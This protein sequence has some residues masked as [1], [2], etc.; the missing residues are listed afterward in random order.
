MCINEIKSKFAKL[1]GNKNKPIIDRV[2]NNYSNVFILCK[3]ES[4]E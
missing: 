3:M 2:K 4:L 1:T